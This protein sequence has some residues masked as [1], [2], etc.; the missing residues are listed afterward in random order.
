MAMYQISAVCNAVVIFTQ[1]EL[2]LVYPG[3]QSTNKALRTTLI[4]IRLPT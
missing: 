1:W 2:F 4:K 3:G